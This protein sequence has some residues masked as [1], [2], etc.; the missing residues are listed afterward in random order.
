M[1]VESNDI[2]VYGAGGFAREVAW[3]AGECGKTVVAFIDDNAARHGQRVND[4]EVMGLEQA[5]AKFPNVAF[6]IGIGNP[7]V[8]EAVAGKAGA[9]ALRPAVLIDPRVARS[10]WIEIGEGTVICA[11]STLTT[12]I[13]LGRHVQVNLHCTIG[14]DVVMEDYV[15]LAPGVHVSGWVH[16]KRGAYVGTGATIINGTE[17]KPIVVGEGAVIGAG[18][19][20]VKNVEPG[21]TVVGIPAKPLSR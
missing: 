3:L 8:R 1:Q 11:G 19:C 21:A 18:A 13:A 17:A 12:N 14:H 15:T 5:A 10:R 9:A 4:A 2:V 6:A 7:N 16:L 20:V